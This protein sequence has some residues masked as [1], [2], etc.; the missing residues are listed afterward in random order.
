MHYTKDQFFRLV[1]AVEDQGGTYL[2]DLCSHR[3]YELLGDKARYKTVTIG[4]CG[5]VALFEM[6]YEDMH[7]GVGPITMCAVCDSM[8]LMP[9][10]ADQV[11]G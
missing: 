4:G 11:A 5:E 1:E 2:D 6:A 9:R 8:G 3:T 7:G 10:F